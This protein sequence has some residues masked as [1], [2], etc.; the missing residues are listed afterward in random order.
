MIKG[1]IHSEYIIIPKMYIPNKIAKL[2]G[3]KIDRTRRKFI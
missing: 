3:T 2:L 1:S